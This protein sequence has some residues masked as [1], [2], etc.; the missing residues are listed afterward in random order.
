M[1]LCFRKAI[2]APKDARVIHSAHQMGVYTSVSEF[3][4]RNIQPL[5]ETRAASDVTTVGTVT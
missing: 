3:R 2:T 4:A 5:R 1:Q